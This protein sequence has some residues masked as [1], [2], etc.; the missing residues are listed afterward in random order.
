MKAHKIKNFNS[1]FKQTKQ[2]NMKT[3]VQKAIFLK[4]FGTSFF[5]FKKISFDYLA[6]LVNFKSTKCLN[7][8]RKLEK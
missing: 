5:N 2:E 6:E 7:N 1:K 4:D 3:Q 8:H